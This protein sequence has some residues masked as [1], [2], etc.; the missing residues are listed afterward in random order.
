MQKGKKFNFLPT[1]PKCTTS[2]TNY[3]GKCPFL[4]LCKFQGN[5]EEHQVQDGFQISQ[6]KPFEIS[7]RPD[8]TF[9]VGI[10]PGGE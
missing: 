7:E 2:C 10:L 9:Q 6:W 5:P 1:F 4:D 8:G 3:F